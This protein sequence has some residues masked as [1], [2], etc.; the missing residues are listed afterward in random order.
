[1][2]KAFRE[3]LIKQVPADDIPELIRTS[4]VS[5]VLARLASAPAPE[6]SY[7][8]LMRAMFDGRLETQKIKGRHYVPRRALASA[9]EIIGMPFNSGTGA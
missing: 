3:A 1:M 7:G 9:A 5:G 6:G 8:R 4:E 2:T